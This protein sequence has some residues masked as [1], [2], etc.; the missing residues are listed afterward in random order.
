[1]PVAVSMSHS[2]WSMCT[3]SWAAV[4][5]CAGFVLP[6]LTWTMPKLCSLP[7][8]TLSSTTHLTAPQS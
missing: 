1:M 3:I 6:G 4:C 2:P 5:Q 8:T 7:A